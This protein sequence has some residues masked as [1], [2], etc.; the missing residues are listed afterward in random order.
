[1]LCNL[2]NNILSAVKNF[3]TEM[4]Q[5]MRHGFI[6]IL[7]IIC[8]YGKGN[9]HVSTIKRVQDC[10]VH[11]QSDGYGV[12]GSQSCSHI[13]DATRPN[14][15]C[16]GLLY[17]IQ[18]FSRKASASAGQAWVHF[19]MVIQQHLQCFQWEILEHPVPCKLTF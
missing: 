19:A 18:D 12:L 17:S 2:F 16:S 15:Q 1:V 13:H 14:N 3:W 4:S 6:T 7:Q 5:Q 10:E 11:W 8:Q 9:T